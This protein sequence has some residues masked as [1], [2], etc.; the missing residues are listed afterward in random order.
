ML[1]ARFSETLPSLCELKRVGQEVVEDLSQTVC[2]ADHRCR[3]AV[4]ELHRVLEP[5]VLRGCREGLLHV[6]A[7]LL[8]GHIAELE[9]DRVRFDLGEVQHVVEELQEIGP[10]RA[11]DVRVA[12]LALGQIPVGV[13]LELLGQDEHA[14]ERRPQ[15]VRHVREE[16]GLVLRRDG[17]LL[18]LL[19]DQ[20][21][22]L[23]DLLV[24][25]LEVGVRLVQLLL[26]RLQLLRLRL[27]LL[28]QLLG[29]R[30]GLH[31]VQDQANAL[32]ELIEQ[33]LVRLAEGGKG[34]EFDHCAH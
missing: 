24:L 3:Q 16:L 5:L 2:V 7:E 8:E 27:G 21:L 26:A 23:F 32:G 33:R 25:A 13:V 12:D 1:V 31:G 34:R 10:R 9:L 20:A 14:V 4:V 18:G 11:D 6:V 17:E 29:D 15:L 19:L 28:E 30:V 22:R